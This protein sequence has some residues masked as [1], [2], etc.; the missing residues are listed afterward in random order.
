MSVHHNSA[1]LPLDVFDGQEQPVAKLVPKK[2]GK[3]RKQSA[4]L[5]AAPQGDGPVVTEAKRAKLLPEE[6]PED[7]VAPDATTPG[8]GPKPGEPVDTLTP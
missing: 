8:T 4:A 3:K 7:P 6:E 2:K 5:S 1:D